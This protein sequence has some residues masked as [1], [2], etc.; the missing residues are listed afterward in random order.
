LPR[1]PA[2]VARSLIR[3]AWTAAGSTRLPSSIAALSAL[4]NERTAARTLA[5]EAFKMETTAS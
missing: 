2:T 1:T 4:R 3:S 5:L